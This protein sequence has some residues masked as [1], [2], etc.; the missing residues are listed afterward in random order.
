MSPVKRAANR[1]RETGIDD[2]DQQCRKKLAGFENDGFTLGE[3]SDV[4]RFALPFPKMHQPIT[5]AERSQQQQRQQVGNENVKSA[6]PCIGDAFPGSGGGEDE[7]K[8]V[9]HA[10][11]QSMNRRARQTEVKSRN[12]TQEKMTHIH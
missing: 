7:Q 1:L 8:G 2:D 4:K 9:K 6:A 11:Q 12:S 3:F 5:F 10:Q